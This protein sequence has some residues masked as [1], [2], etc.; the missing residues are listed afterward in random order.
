MPGMMLVR[1]FA[2]YFYS[3]YP[4]GFAFVVMPVLGGWHTTPFFEK[5]GEM[6][7]V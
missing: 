3:L 7:V 5:S 6:V 2:Y 4:L 1:W